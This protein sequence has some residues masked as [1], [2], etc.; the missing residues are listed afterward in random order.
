MGCVMKFSRREMLKQTGRFRVPEYK[1]LA[2]DSHELYIYICIFIYLFF[3]STY[4][5]IVTPPP[6]QGPPLLGTPSASSP[7]FKRSTG[8]SLGLSQTLHLTDV[9]GTIFH[10]LSSLEEFYALANCSLLKPPETNRKNN[11]VRDSLENQ[12]GKSKKH[13][14]QMEVHIS[15]LFLFSGAQDDSIQGRHRNSKPRCAVGV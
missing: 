2:D 5:L 14:K 8:L 9:R 4:I 7:G 1:S 3:I 10:L 6:S 15:K 13:V 11:P 12:Q